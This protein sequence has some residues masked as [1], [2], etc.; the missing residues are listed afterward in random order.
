[1]RLL[2]A[3]ALVHLASVAAADTD[4]KRADKLFEDGRRYLESKEYALACTAFEQSQ[5][6]DPAIGTQLNIARCYE[7]WGHFAAAVKAF[8][9]ADRLATAKRDDK[10]AKAARKKV[11]ELTPKVPHLSVVVPVD[12]DA[13]AVYMLDGKEIDLAALTADLLLES[14]D[15]AIEVRTP[16]APPQTT[17]V[18]LAIGEH[19]RLELDVPKPVVIKPPPPPPPN[20]GPPPPPPRNQLRFYGGIALT[21]TG[22]VA[23][24][25]A[26]FVALVARSDY[27]TAIASCPNNLCTTY[28]A[29]RDTENARSHANYASLIGAGGIALAGAGVYL[30]MTSH[31]DTH[32][33]APV[34]APGAVGVA[35][36][37]SW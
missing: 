13:S 32:A 30:I 27:N 3:C 12:A 7:E 34:V 11:A 24:G 15:H 8:E 16:G 6:A 33:V 31:G 5:Q 14:G 29:Y 25:A 35:Y 23:L 28:K 22:G 2:V 10:R 1:M 9:E 20:V 4:K 26:S 18:A 19:K 17:K 36:G 21:A 37:G